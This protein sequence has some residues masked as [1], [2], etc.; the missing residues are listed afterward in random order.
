MFSGPTAGTPADSTTFA[1]RTTTADAEQ[2]RATRK[3]AENGNFSIVQC[4]LLK[5]HQSSCLLYV[6]F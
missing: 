6:I 2:L 5:I 1:T 3:H 4:L